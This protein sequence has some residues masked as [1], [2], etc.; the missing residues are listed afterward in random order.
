MHGDAG[1]HPA[2]R[3]SV[4]TACVVLG[5]LAAAPPADAAAIAK[6]RFGPAGKYTGTGTITIERQDGRRVAR[7]SRDFTAQGAIRLRL[8]FATSRAGRTFVDAGPMAKRG[9]Q[10]LRV[11][12]AVNLRRHRYA[13]VWCVAVDEPITLAVLR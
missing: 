12:R 1:R 10:T 6:G 8:R 13:I 3:L 5:L 9:A 7:F 11:P 4:V 2:G